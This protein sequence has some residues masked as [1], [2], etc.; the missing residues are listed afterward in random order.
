MAR[1]MRRN[2]V[3]REK[4]LDDEDLVADKDFLQEQDGGV[5]GRP[6]GAEALV[7]GLV[8]IAWIDVAA[9]PS[10]TRVIW[11]SGHWFW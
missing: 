1:K 5:M 6:S 3:L 7:E 10:R 8:S 11:S 4:L 9:F 2:E